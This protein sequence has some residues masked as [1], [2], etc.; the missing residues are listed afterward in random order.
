MSISKVLEL[1]KLIKSKVF[2]EVNLYYLVLIIASIAFISSISSIFAHYVFKQESMKL[3]EISCYAVF[4]SYLAIYLVSIFSYFIRNL[5]IHLMT[6]VFV[7][8]ILFF[9]LVFVLYFE[10]VGALAQIKNEDYVSILKERFALPL[11]LLLLFI[12]YVSIPSQPAIA[13]AIPIVYFI[14]LYEIYCVNNL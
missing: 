3:A 13:M 1:P 11:S 4:A 6:P 5:N 7:I 2:T 12:C 10:M 14:V 9:I 8:S